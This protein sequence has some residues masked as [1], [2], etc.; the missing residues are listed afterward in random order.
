MNV[1]ERQRKLS[2]WAEQLRADRNLPLF[3]RREDHRLY[4]LYHLVYEPT[5]LRAAHDRV[6]RN[7]GSITA[8]CDGVNMAQFD[9]RL[10]DNLRQLADELRNQTFRPHPVRRVYI[11]KTGGRMRPLG[12]PSI[13]DRIVQESLRMVLEPVFE[14]EFYNH[15]FGFRPNRST[16]DA[17]AVVTYSAGTRPRYYWVVE[18][19][20]AACFDTI[21]HR[22]LMGLLRRRIRDD[23]LLLLVWRFLRAGVMEGKLF[24]DTVRGTPQGGIIS[25]LLANVYLHEL[26][27]FMERR[28][29]LSPDEKKRR[30]LRGLG[31]FV[32]VRYAD[33]FVVMTNGTREEAEA[34]RS[35][36]Q[37][38]LT[39]ELKLSLSMEKTRIT[40]ID[41]GFRFLGFDIRRHMTGCGVKLP[42]LLIPR[43]SVR[44]VR[45]TVLAITALSSCNQSVNA[46]I[47]ALNHLLR[48]WANHYHNAYNAAR[49][50]Y[51]LDSF[52]FWQFA[53]WLA[54]KFKCRLSQVL[55][56]HYRHAGGVKTLASADKALWRMRTLKCELLRQRTFVNPYSSPNPALE[57]A[58]EFGTAPQWLGNETR[59]GIEDL[60]FAVHRRDNWFCRNC[61]CKVSEATAKLDHVRGVQTFTRPEDA[62]VENNL[63]TLCVL[64]HKHKTQTE[65]DRWMESPV[66]RKLHAGFGGGSAET[67]PDG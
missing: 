4:D 10:E 9:E 19:D 41:D 24:K 62:N 7:S 15:S 46:K 2:L 65:I 11:P 49:V 13:R 17:L 58:N 33:D 22:K 16:K 20:I 66:Q 39:D 29:G 45:A 25:L 54:E 53:H 1:G 35:E 50:F 55:R 12:I 37:Q 43:D 18:G 56:R 42:K 14:G 51:K 57:R 47:V 8:G 61:G 63:Q 32:H 64:C 60:R 26:D 27:M 40:H 23:K 36:L 44:K 3:S 5:W 38:F 34:M 28:T 59:P 31:N 30:R 48:G 21:H 52:V 6:A 67:C